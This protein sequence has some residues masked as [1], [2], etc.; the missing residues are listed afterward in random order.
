MDKNLQG[1][2]FL[3]KG[4]VEK[5]IQMFTEAIEENPHDAVGYV[6][7]ANVLISVGE[8]ERAEQFLKRA[9]EID[10]KASAAYYSYGNLY[11]NKERYDKAAGM[12]EKALAIGPETNDLQYMLG[13]CFVNLGRNE[14]SLPYLQRSV[15]LNDQDIEARFQYALSLARSEVYDEAIKQLETVIKEDS[16]HADAFYNLGVAY[17]AHHDDTE[18][19]LHC[20]D[21]A[22]DIQPNH[23]LAGN[24]KK[25]VEELSEEKGQ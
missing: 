19:S 15:E 13:M 5:A 24:G 20:F 1:I 7:F 3:Q 14:L 25:L 9:I 22:L 21:K 4:N 11:F 8:L 10:E 23:A 6:N 18:K 16:Y 12:F 17:L 2:E